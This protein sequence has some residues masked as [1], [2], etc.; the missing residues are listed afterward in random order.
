MGTGNELRENVFFS[1]GSWKQGLARRRPMKLK[2]IEVCAFLDKNAKCD[3]N[4]DFRICQGWKARKQLNEFWC[5]KGLRTS[6][7]KIIY[8]TIVEGI[9]LSEV[10]EMKNKESRKLQAL[11]VDALRRSCQ[12][13]RLHHIPSNVKNEKKK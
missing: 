3:K 4:I 6:T 8:R 12:I 11:W 10:W 9:V 1:D 7:K 5:R 13:S 2:W